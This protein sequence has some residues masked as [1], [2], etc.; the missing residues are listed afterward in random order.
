MN[1]QEINQRKILNKETLKSKLAY[2]KFKDYRIVFTNGCFDIIHLGHIET[3]HCCT[4]NA[5]K[6]AYEDQI[7]PFP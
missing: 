2:W 3:D 1:Y 6:G 5:D 7:F 4:D